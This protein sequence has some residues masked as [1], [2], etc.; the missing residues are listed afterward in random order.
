MDEQWLNKY[1]PKK[2][3]DIIGN[4]LIIKNIA[5]WL[6]TF[7]NNKTS[8]I[9]L[10]GN[11][12]VGKSLI[13][14][15]LLK[16]YGYEIKTLN[17]KNQRMISDFIKNNNK[18]NLSGKPM[19]L[20]IDD[21][22]SITATTEKN[23]IM[24]LCHINNKNKLFPIILMASFKHNKFV[25]DIKSICIEY[26][27]SNPSKDT[28]LKIINHICATENISIT[29]DAKIEIYKYSQNDTRRL[30]QIL[31]DI[32][33]SNLTDIIDIDTVKKYK[34]IS[35]RKDINIGL[36]TA[37]EILLNNYSS[38]NN[39]LKLFEMDKVL[40][41]ATIYENYYKPA[42]IK[43]QNNSLHLF[44]VL[45]DVSDSISK[46]DVIE[47][48]IYTDQSW[49]LQNIHGFYTCCN[50]SYNMSKYNNDQFNKKYDMKF[51]EDLNRLYLKN[52]NKKNIVKLQKIFNNKPTND[53]LA[54]NKIV[55]GLLKNENYKEIANLMKS[56]NFTVK[57][58]EVI[59]KIDKTN[60]DNKI[61]ITPKIKKHLISLY[62]TSNN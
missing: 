33:I 44:N 35:Y 16:E 56:Y 24:E 11:H 8:N 59:I 37:A 14:N 60:D 10:L 21:I 54:I 62:D 46:G 23:G 41:P 42:I 39:S 34:H 19:A 51:S 32:Y 2:S 52:I 45:S 26:K 22:E 55:I 9:L 49:Y 36:F 15:L 1:E 5:E 47:T 30:I 31:Q 4:Q 3:T 6:K 13:V 53:I 61:K 43:Y 48:K 57:D 17:T 38:I 12:G 40:L 7:Y 28:M 27:L 50:T 18:I 58:I 20:I 25:T 29:D